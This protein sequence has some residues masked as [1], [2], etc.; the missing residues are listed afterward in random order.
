MPPQASDLAPPMFAG[1]DY[2]LYETLMAPYATRLADNLAPGDLNPG[3]RPYFPAPVTLDP[4]RFLAWDTD[5][6]WPQRRF[7]AP[8]EWTVLQQ[9]DGETAISALIAANTSDREA[10]LAALWRLH[11]EGFI[12]FHSAGL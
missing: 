12:L 10:W 1:R 3:W 5:P 9:I 6:I 4:L 8:L 2:A 11:V 7:L